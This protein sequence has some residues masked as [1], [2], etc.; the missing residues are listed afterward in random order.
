MKGYIK[1]RNII[2][3]ENLP[4]SFQEGDEVELVITPIPPTTYPLSK[5]IS[6]LGQK[7]R[8]IRQEIVDSGISLLSAEEVE[9]EKA[10]R[11]GGYQ[12]DDS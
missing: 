12:G 3:L 9:R 11:R 2:L 10:E 1:G 6:S 7:L 4:D 5:P 8:Q